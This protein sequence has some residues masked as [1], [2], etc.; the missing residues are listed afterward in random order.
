MDRTRRY[1]GRHATYEAL[2]YGRSRVINGL[3]CGFHLDV[4]G[5]AQ[6]GEFNEVLLQLVLRRIVKSEVGAF[7]HRTEYFGLP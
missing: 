3:K 6:V 7:C 2:R 5:L 1:V 4:P